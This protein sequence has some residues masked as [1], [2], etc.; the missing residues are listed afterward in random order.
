M[1]ILLAEKLTGLNFINWYRNLRIVPRYEKKIK[2]MEQP[3]GP[4]PDPETPDL[5]N[6]DKYYETVNL[7]QKEDGQSLSSYLFKMK[8]YLDTLERLGYAM[9]K[10]EGYVISTNTQDVGWS[11]KPK[12]KKRRSA[13]DRLAMN[14]VCV[15]GA[16]ST[17][18]SNASQSSA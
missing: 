4:A 15:V 16:S 13:D 18:E 1:S 7:K 11:I 3:I 5:D 2:F 14:M 9:L 17:S 6:I 12:M 10:D 8:S